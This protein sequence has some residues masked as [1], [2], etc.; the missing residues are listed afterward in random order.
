MKKLALILILLLI[1]VSLYGADFTKDTDKADRIADA[2]MVAYNAWYS[3]YGEY[4]VG[5][6][7]R[8]STRFTA[9]LGMS[10][11]K[12]VEFNTFHSTKERGVSLWLWHIV[13]TKVD[14]V[15]QKDLYDTVKPV[16]VAPK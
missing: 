12:L 3:S 11:T 8:Y 7:C 13:K 10:A 14:S 15:D 5:R 4:P 9:L 2:Y 16:E 1:P 6:D